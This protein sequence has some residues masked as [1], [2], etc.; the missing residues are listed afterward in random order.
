MD[1]AVPPLSNRLGAV[2]FA[3]REPYAADHSDRREAKDPAAGEGNIGSQYG[4]GFTDRDSGH[5]AG[6][7]CAHRCDGGHNIFEHVEHSE[8]PQFHYKTGRSKTSSRK[9]IGA[10]LNF[11]NLSDA[12]AV[13]L[14]LLWR[15]LHANDN[16][17]IH[18]NILQYHPE[19]AARRT[20]KKYDSFRWLLAK[21]A[22]SSL[23]H[24][25][26]PEY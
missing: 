11:F 9:S 13:I 23:H 8:V 5:D 18:I 16:K 24:V 6:H 22:S 3:P 25:N 26:V 15:K 1:A 4:D 12:A 21:R 2:A 17:V 20:V 19:M 14:I 10:W 7:G